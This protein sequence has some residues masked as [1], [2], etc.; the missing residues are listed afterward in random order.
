MR[1][2]FISGGFPNAPGWPGA[3]VKTP[4]PLPLDKAG[5]IACWVVLS[6]KAFR[7]RS[8]AQGVPVVGGLSD[9]SDRRSPVEAMRSIGVSC[10]ALIVKER[11]GC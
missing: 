4:I 9:P 11:R 6:V 5:R 7:V 2:W 10:V 3:S 8:A 1:H